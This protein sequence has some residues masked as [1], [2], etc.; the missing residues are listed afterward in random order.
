MKVL[1]LTVTVP[2]MSLLEAAAAVV[3]AELPVK[4]LPVT[5]AVPEPLVRGRCELR[6][7]P[8][9]CG[10][11]AGE[12]AAAHRRRTASLSRPPPR[13]A[14][15]PVKVLSR[16]VT[17]PTGPLATPPPSPPAASLMKVTAKLTRPPPCRR[18]SCR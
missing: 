17:V 16:T 18:R 11:V 9:A 15:L 4:V 1:S 8:P 6:S 3:P 5:V 12:G 14:E 10:G 13:A 7:P 2:P